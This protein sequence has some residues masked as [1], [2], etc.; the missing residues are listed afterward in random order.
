M[1][2][3]IALSLSLIST[4]QYAQ[5]INRII[6]TLALIS[7]ASFAQTCIPDQITPTTKA[8]QF[9][10]N[11][12]GTITDI[13]NGL[14]WSQCTIGQ[15]FKDG[16]CVGEPKHFKSWQEALKGAQENANYLGMSNWRLPNIKE[17]NS[18]VERSCH[19]PAINLV[20]F[21][22]T[23]SAV[24]WS[25]TYDVNQIN[26]STSIN[27]LIIDFTDGTEFL[28][29]VNKNRLLRLVRELD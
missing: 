3:Q 20:A 5:M 15:E 8:G 28:T 12:D 26:A 10:P 23:P 9:Y 25:S 14:M 29:D 1:I 22:S 2:K 17:L 24:Y 16:N 21:P 7:S 11:N 19:G 6:L 18:I 27:G 4:S 13:V